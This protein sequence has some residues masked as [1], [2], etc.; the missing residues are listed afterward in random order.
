MTPESGPKVGEMV[1]LKRNKAIVVGEVES[2]IE[3]GLTLV[4]LGFFYL[5]PLPNV[6]ELPTWT[7]SS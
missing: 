2:I 6:P 5:K 7:V 1:T 3:Y 4:D